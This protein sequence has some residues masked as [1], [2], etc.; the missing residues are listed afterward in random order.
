[1]INVRRAAG[2]DSK[3]GREVG[4]DGGRNFVRGESGSEKKKQR[5]GPERKEGRREGERETSGQPLALLC[6]C[7]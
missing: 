7:P 3:S 6:L 5:E 1:M 2:R 4:G